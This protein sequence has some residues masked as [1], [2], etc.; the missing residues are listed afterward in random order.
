LKNTPQKRE[1]GQVM[2]KQQLKTTGLGMSLELGLSKRA[3]GVVVVS[4]LALTGI[5]GVSQ[6]A[7]AD[8]SHCTPGD[9]TLPIDGGKVVIETKAQLMHFS[10]SQ[11]LYRSSEIV[12]R[13]SIGDSFDVSD[14]TWIPV[15][16]V[17]VDGSGDIVELPFTGTFDGAGS[18]VIFSPANVAVIGRRGFFGLLENAVVSG[19]QLEGTV[20]GPDWSRIGGLAGVAR[21]SEIEN[22]SFKGTVSNDDVSRTGGLVGEA[23]N[24][25]ISN[26][27]FE[28]FIILAGEASRA[29]GLVGLAENS[30][31]TNSRSDADISSTLDD[32][33]NIGG[34]VGRADNSYIGASSSTGNTQVAGEYVGGLVGQLNSSTVHDSNSDSNVTST[35]NTVG[36]LVGYAGNST[37]TNS[38]ALNSLVSGGLKVGGLIGEAQN[39]Y[40]ERSSATATVTGTQEVGGLVGYLNGPLSASFSSGSVNGVVSV[41]GLVG[42]VLQDFGTIANSYSTATVDAPTAGGFHTAGGLVG[43]LSDPAPVTNSWSKGAVVGLNPGGLIAFGT[44]STVNGSFWDTQTSGQMSSPGGGTSK[45]TADMTSLSTFTAA[46]WQIVS[47]WQTYDDSTRVWGICSAVNEG[48]P[49]LLWEYTTNPCATAPTDSGSGS[50]SG[51]VAAGP[52]VV[53]EA[54]VTPRTIKQ[55]SIRPASGDRPARLLGKSLNRD[56]LFV[57]DSTRLSAEARKSL[58]QA[59]RLAK[60]SDGK[61]AVTGFAAMTN[62]GSAYEKSVALK[63]ARVVARFLR[64]KGFDDWIYFHGLSGRQGQ[65]FEGD[66]RRVEI[67]ILK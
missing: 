22:S 63:R 50:S 46:T 26:S 14:C 45:T 61:V 1:S 2:S 65:A 44:P 8:T 47:G 35:N 9:I 43:W 7:K 56:V 60:A 53:P 12:L 28:G 3:I 40:L 64:A 59:A 16:G 24:T 11:D 29:G 27:S 51:A 23:I 31:I 6:E 10:I 5:V 20:T 55:R 4:L 13:P 58:R 66:P 67:R 38:R 57:A 48:Y 39:T 36:G 25:S 41:G 42:F 52:V 62:R 21:N 54:A 49:F 32:D 17:V 34:L 19:L 37:I 33:G 30:T 18:T 15:G